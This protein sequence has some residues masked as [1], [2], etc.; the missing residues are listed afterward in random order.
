ML[1][2]VRWPLDPKLLAERGAK[3]GAEAGGL[4]QS[5]HQSLLAS[6]RLDLQDYVNLS[7][8]N[9]RAKLSD[10]LGPGGSSQSQGPDELVRSA[11]AELEQL[12][13]CRK[14]GQSPDGLASRNGGNDGNDAS[15]QVQQSEIKAVS[16]VL[17]PVEDKATGPGM[18]WLGM[19]GVFA[20]CVTLESVM[21]IWLLRGGLP[22][23]GLEAYALAILL[24]M[25]NV[26]GFGIGAGLLLST[27]HRYFGR[28]RSYLSQAA[29]GGW[30]VLVFGF[31]Y[32]AGRHRELYAYR[33]KAVQADPTLLNSTFDN[34]IRDVPLDPIEWELTALLV[35]LLGI[36]LCAVGCAKGFTFA[37]KMVGDSGLNAPPRRNDQYR[38]KK[39]FSAMDDGGGTKAAPPHHRQLFD[40]FASLPQRYQDKLTQALRKQVADWYRSLDEERRNVT[41]MVDTLKEKE[42]TRACIDIVEQAFIAAY[43][44]SSPDKVDLQRVEAHR[45]EKHPD[46]L[47]SVTVLEPGVLNEAAKLVDEWGKSGQSEFE[48]RIAAAH[49]EIT[50]I[51]KNYQRPVL[52]DSPPKLASVNVAPTATPRSR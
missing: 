17:R 44:G 38:E 19:I 46:P 2:K 47:L 14:F 28:T 40:A 25:I 35:A 21:N 5:A 42:T 20:F 29:W 8:S 31:N 16:A 43:N 18:Q 41:I 15:T 49:D 1:R 24:S 22:G 39:V 12:A 37:R 23:G 4:W 50:R 32:V 34:S 26:G 3:A 9:L 11:E 52:G 51:W 36:V 7:L 48:K 6:L 10:P 45:E 27:L 30:V 13:L 33:T